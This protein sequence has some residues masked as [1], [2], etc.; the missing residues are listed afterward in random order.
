LQGAVGSGLRQ[1]EAVGRGSAGG[2]RGEDGGEWGPRSKPL[3]CKG[4]RASPRGLQVVEDD[5]GARRVGGLAAVA[6]VAAVSVLWLC[7]Q[8]PL[9]N[10]KACWRQGSN[11]LKCRVRPPFT[12]HALPLRVPSIS[13]RALACPSCDALCILGILCK[14]ANARNGQRQTAAGLLA[15]V[16][17][18]LREVREP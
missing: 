14:T 18:G 6:D 10:C 5:E 15:G 9:A 13:L 1:R 12:C 8:L 2:W 7:L 4:P 3:S 16:S 11:E 17:V